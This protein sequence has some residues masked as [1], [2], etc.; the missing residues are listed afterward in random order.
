MSSNINSEE[1]KKRNEDVPFAEKSSILSK[2][3]NL[4]F[5]ERK[6]KIEG[7]SNPYD[8]QYL[9]DDVDEQFKN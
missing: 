3:L 1:E 8:Y 4:F 5:T 6:M 9:P 7:N 2:G